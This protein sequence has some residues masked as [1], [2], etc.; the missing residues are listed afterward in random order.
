MERAFRVF[1]LVFAVAVSSAVYAAPPRVA[2]IN[3]IQDLPGI[4]RMLSMPGHQGPVADRNRPAIQEAFAA[5]KTQ[6]GKAAPAARPGILKSMADGTK[7]GSPERYVV[8]YVCAWYGVD[9][10]NCIGYLTNVAC[11]W[12]RGFEKAYKAK[13]HVERFDYDAGT[14]F[15][16]SYQE[17][18]FRL[19]YALYERNQDFRLLHDIVTNHSDGAGA[20]VITSVTAD[21]AKK[22]PRGLLHVAAISNKGHRL[23]AGVLGGASIPIRTMEDRS[24]LRGYRAYVGRV[25]ADLKD[26][27]KDTAARLLRR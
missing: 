24:G 27:L 11:W 23:V 20:T 6:L 3:G 8:Y 7:W 5:M 26:P 18:D 14:V 22:H 13:F 17:M 19:L 16:F 2:A 1:V 4:E 9:Y 21:A 15:P 10:K 12:E 25:A